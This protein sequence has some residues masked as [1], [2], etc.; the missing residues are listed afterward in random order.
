M[1]EFLNRQYVRR[2]LISHNYVQTLATFDEEL[3]SDNLNDRVVFFL[4]IIASL[5]VQAFESRRE[6]H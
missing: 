2:Y 3:S 1:S 4:L 5:I 6:Y